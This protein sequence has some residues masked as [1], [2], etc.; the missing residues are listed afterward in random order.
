MA[1]ARIRQDGQSP[2]LYAVRNNYVENSWDSFKISSTERV[3]VR[4]IAIYD[5]YPLLVV[6]FR[7]LLMRSKITRMCNLSVKNTTNGTLIYFVINELG[8]LN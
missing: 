7:I 5:G 8:G 3:C 6:F 4:E 2:G 1:T